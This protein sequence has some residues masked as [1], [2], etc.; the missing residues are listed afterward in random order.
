MTKTRTRIEKTDFLD[1]VENRNNLL[2]VMS[3]NTETRT[4]CHI[5]DTSRTINLQILQNHSDDL[6]TS[7]FTNGKDVTSV[8]EAMCNAA[9][10]G[11]SAC[12]EKMYDLVLMSFSESLDPALCLAAERNHPICMQ[13]AA[14]LGATDFKTAQNA[15]TVHDHSACI[16][17]AVSLRSNEA[18]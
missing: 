8:R 14:N 4:L 5:C 10:L 7:E 16:Q 17:K 6:P 3:T 11:H 13:V 18:K 1:A 15:A 2:H 12:M 9:N